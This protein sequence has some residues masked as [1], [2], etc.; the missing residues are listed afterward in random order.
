VYDSDLCLK[1]ILQKVIR[2][3]SALVNLLNFAQ[4]SAQCP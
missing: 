4:K 2:G 1:L 3:G